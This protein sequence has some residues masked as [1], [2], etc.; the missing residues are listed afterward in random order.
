[1][2]RG[3]LD[4]LEPPRYGVTSGLGIHEV[5]TKRNF[6]F[7][8]NCASSKQICLLCQYDV[9]CHDSF[10]SIVCVCVRCW[11]EVWKHTDDCGQRPRLS[12]TLY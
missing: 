3:T 1:M 7:P 5:K 6:R 12:Q 8:P 9:I 10:K 11:E 2:R 4:V